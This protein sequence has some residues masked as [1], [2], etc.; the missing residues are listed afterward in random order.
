MF[1]TWVSIG[2][3][4]VLA[5]TLLL[6]LGAPPAAAHADIVTTTPQED[7]RVAEP[8]SAVAVS[9]AERPGEGSE[10]IV[11]DGCRRE[12]SGE[13]VLG[14]L[15]LSAPVEEGQ[16]GRWDVEV[17]SVSAKDGHR[18]EDAYSFQVFGDSVCDGAA[19]P[20]GNET[21]SEVELGEGQP[22]E[23]EETSFPFVPL[24]VGTT[25]VLAL[26]LALKRPWRKR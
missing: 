21:D 10:I 6:A 19:G 5:A 9:L 25:A 11:T 22:R 23:N 15:T 16:P 2:W 1:M 17:I 4:S 13:P 3:K 24:A 26:A 7:T 20:D 14:Q 8:P 18:I 12:I